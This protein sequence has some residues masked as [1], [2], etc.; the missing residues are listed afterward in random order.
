MQEVA[1]YVQQVITRNQ[2]Q[3]EQ[4]QR[5]QPSSGSDD[6]LHRTTVL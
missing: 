4:H 3:Q 6:V 2:K 1:D 5:L